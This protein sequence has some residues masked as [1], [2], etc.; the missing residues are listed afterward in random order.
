MKVKVTVSGTL[1]LEKE[2]IKLLKKASAGEVLDTM[3]YQASNLKA[4]VSKPKE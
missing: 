2:D 1:N 4:T 3:R